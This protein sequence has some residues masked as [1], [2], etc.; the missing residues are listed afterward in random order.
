[1]LEGIG[2]KEYMPLY[3]TW[4]RLEHSSGKTRG[5]ILSV[6]VSLSLILEFYHSMMRTQLILYPGMVVSTRDLIRAQT[7]FM[8]VRAYFSL[9]FNRKY[10]RS[11]QGTLEGA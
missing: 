5:W 7:K 1:M 3:L 11:T 2:G 4:A 9:V 8:F 10:N 6:Q